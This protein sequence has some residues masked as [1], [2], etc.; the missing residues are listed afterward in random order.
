MFQWY[1]CITFVF[2]CDKGKKGDIIIL[3]VINFIASVNMAHLVGAKIYFSDVDKSTG[4]M[5]PKNLVDCIKN[6][7]KKIKAVITMYNGGSPNNAKVFFQLK[8]I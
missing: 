8:K 7:L 1:I 5:T 4:Q 6:K 2:A 3:P